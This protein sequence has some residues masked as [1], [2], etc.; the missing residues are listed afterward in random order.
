MFSEGGGGK[1][2]SNKLKESSLLL[3]AGGFKVS[4]CTA[5][6][7]YEV[8]GSSPACSVEHVMLSVHTSALR[9]SFRG[10]YL[11]KTKWLRHSLSQ[12]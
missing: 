12:W 10:V 6:T 2:K 3:I 7:E 8:W 4:D 5:G 11:C 9:R 1:V